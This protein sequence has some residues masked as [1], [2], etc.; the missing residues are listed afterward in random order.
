MSAGLKQ[1]ILLL[2]ALAMIP[3]LCTYNVR[4]Y[5]MRFMHREINSILY[6]IHIPARLEKSDLSA[7]TARQIL[8]HFFKNKS[9]SGSSGGYNYRYFSP[10]K[11]ICSLDRG[12]W[13]IL[14]ISVIRM[15][16]VLCNILL[17]VLVA[18]KSS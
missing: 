9:P 12:R 13:S 14:K 6:I 2:T 3:I 10:S 8:T 18:I 17:C 15:Y 16:A 7:S 11:Y 4:P 5:N 1:H